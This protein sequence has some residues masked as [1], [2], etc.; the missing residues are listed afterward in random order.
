ML[1]FFENHSVNY[2]FTSGMLL[3]AL[4]V[5]IT[6]FIELYLR[7]K[8]AKTWIKFSDIEKKQN[9]H[10]LKEEKSF[11]ETQGNM[12]SKLL[13]RYAD[14]KDKNK[15]LKKAFEDSVAEIT[16]LRANEKAY[17]SELKKLYAENA[18][19]D[20][21]NGLLI[22]EINDLKA[23]RDY[24]KE[25]ALHQKHSKPV[26]QVESKYWQLT[27]DITFVNNLF[28]TGEVYKKSHL[29]PSSDSLLFLIAKNNRSY[30]VDKSYFKPVVK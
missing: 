13:V 21:R 28:E 25:R 6:L 4:L 9:R 27:K 14:L 11:S 8:E 20:E 3:V 23:N 7:F 22:D 16:E 12:Y 5:V 10:E 15:E 1:N 18:K 30:L 24:W 19:Q 29:K 2:A 26:K 17:N